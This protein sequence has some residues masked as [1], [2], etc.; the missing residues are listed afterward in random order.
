MWFKDDRERRDANCKVGCKLRSS[1]IKVYLIKQGSRRSTMWLF[2]PTVM[3]QDFNRL[4]V[5]ALKIPETAGHAMTIVHCYRVSQSHLVQI[6]RVIEQT[7]YHVTRL[8]KAVVSTHMDSH[9]VLLSY[10]QW[11]L[12]S[13]L[14]SVKSQR[15]G[16]PNHTEYIEV[17]FNVRTSLIT[18]SAI[19]NK[20]DRHHQWCRGL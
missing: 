20:S 19:Q 3:T 6:Y 5:P 14:I 15:G 8:Y 17:S 7:L 11:V 4:Q 13:V 16:C 10:E 1:Q 9:A 18:L 12:G 2:C